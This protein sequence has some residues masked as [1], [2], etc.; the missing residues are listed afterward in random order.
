MLRTSRGQWVAPPPVCP[1]SRR[2]STPPKVAPDRVA[3]CGEHLDVTST[4][5]AVSAAP[6]AR[7]APTIR[8]VSMAAIVLERGRPGIVELPGSDP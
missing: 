2:A 4:G 8:R 3:H 7:S 6:T 1:A 5:A